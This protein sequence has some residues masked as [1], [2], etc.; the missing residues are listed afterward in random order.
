MGVVV[1]WIGHEFL[2]IKILKD[3]HINDILLLFLKYYQI[4]IYKSYE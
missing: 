1:I 2:F 3:G 4:Y